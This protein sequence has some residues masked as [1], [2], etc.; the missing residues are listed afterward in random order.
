[1]KRIAIIGG[2]IS[3]LSAAYDLARAEFECTIIDP[4]PRLGG[5]I[6]TER[7]E[8]CVVEDGP[9]SFL[10]QKPWALE[11]IHELGLKDQVIGSNDHLR[12]TFVLRAGKLV[13]LPDGIQFMVPTKIAPML[14][15]PLLGWG[16]K[17]KMAM[18]WFRQPGKAREE[19]S[20]ADQVSGVLIRGVMPV[21]EREVSAVAGLLEQGS[22]ADLQAGSHRIVLGSDLAQHLETQ[23][24]DSVIMVAELLHFP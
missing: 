1:M 12:K 19:R 17:A 7:R 20:V 6:Q 23:L 16:T 13:P 15:T 14:T 5:V 9:D 22:L 18:E 8:N 11:L 3:G 21:L 2:G 4:G 24:G 10:A